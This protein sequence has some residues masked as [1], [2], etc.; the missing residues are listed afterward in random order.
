MASDISV[1]MAVEGEN[2]FKSALKAANAEVK[3]LEAQ[4]QASAD[5][6]D[7]FTSI[8]G[9]AGS[10]AQTLG[11]I[12]EA[13]GQKMSIL[14][15][16]YENAA[17][18]LSSLGDALDQARSEYGEN[19]AEA[20]KAANAYNKQAAEVSKLKTQMAQTSTQMAQTGKAMDSLGKDADEL[21][22][23]LG[24]AGKEA[25]LFGSLLKAN[26][27]SELIT[28]VGHAL[29]DGV[30]AG[31]EA[32]K[33]LTMQAVE[34]YG[35]FEQLEG[36]VKTIFG[37]GAG[38]QVVENARRAF[39]TAQIS[40]NE[41]METVTSF[42]ASL[43]NSL[44]GDTEEAVSLADMAITDMA[45]NANKMGTE[46]SS[47]QTAYAGFARSNYT[48]L[49]N[50]KLGFAGSKEGM[51]DLLDKAE[52][53]SGIH[54]DISSF[55]DIVQAIHIVQENMD[56]A[57]ATAEEA[58][59]T[60]EGSV[61]AMKAAWKNL[62]TGMGD[63]NAD[64][65]QL[66][67][68]FARTAETAIDNILPVAE[69]ALEAVGTLID[70]LAPTV[71][72]KMPG[73]V[74]EV[75]PII[76]EALGMIAANVAL[77]APE[78]A[79]AFMDG[80]LSSLNI[81]P[82]V[83]D[84]LEAVFLPWLT[85][86]KDISAGA[87]ALF[88]DKE[89]YQEYGTAVAEGLGSAAEAS[90]KFAGKQKEVVAAVQE[91]VPALTE[92]EQAFKEATASMAEIGL[93][94]YEAISS[95]GDLGEAYARLS[96]EMAKL[97]GSGDPAI[98][99]IVN[100]RLAMLELAATMQDLSGEYPA[101]ASM[102]E[103]YGFSVQQTSQWLL[104]NGLTA[105]EWANQVSGATD[106]VVNSFETVNT[107]LGM[108]LDEMKNNLASNIE[109]YNNWNSNIQTLMAA[110]VAS[111]SEGAVAFVQYM[112][113]MGIGAADQVAAMMS[114]V[115]GNLA[116]FGSLFEGAGGEAMEAIYNQITGANLGEAAATAGAEIPEGLGTGV[117]GSQDAV[118]G[119]VEEAVNAAV[120]KAAQVDFS[121]AGTTEMESL[122]SGIS[123]AIDTVTSAA[124]DVVNAAKDTADAIEFASVGTARMDDLAS[125]ISS[126]ADGVEN[127]AES[128]VEGAKGR[129]E[130][131]DFT[132]VGLNLARGIASGITAGTGFI[133]SAAISAVNAAK[134]AA[135]AAAGI[136]SPS[137][138][139][140]DEV[141]QMLTKG[142]AAGMVTSEAMS[143]LEDAA[144]EI[145]EAGVNQAQV[146]VKAWEKVYSSFYDTQ[147]HELFM[148]KRH[149]ATNTDIINWYKSMQQAV[150]EQAEHYRA[151]GVEENS[152][153]IM[154]L[155]EKWW[156]YQD[157]IDDIYEEIGD[158]AGK[159]AKKTQ[160]AYEKAMKEIQSAQESMAKKLSSF[161][162]WGE[163]RN[164]NKILSDP[165]EQIRLLKEY[166]QALADMSKYAGEHL[167]EDIL[168]MG[169]A[170]TVDFWHQM[171]QMGGEDLNK[172]LA[173]YET[174]YKMSDQISE[175]Y[176]KAQV[177]ALQ[178]EMGLLSDSVEPVMNEVG[179]LGTDAATAIA[180]NFAAQEGAITA[181]FVTTLQNAMSAAEAMVSSVGGKQSLSTS[182]Y[183]NG[184][185]NVVNGL[186]SSMA[187]QSSG[188]AT[189]VLEVDGAKLASATIQDYRNVSKANP[190]VRSA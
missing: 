96:G 67:D 77:H 166:D 190:E 21:T 66:I 153:Y 183:Y 50:L 35:A 4:L 38:S 121:S 118:S 164:G 39:E 124:E 72:E 184:L 2:T 10:K 187:S 65:D 130:A 144:T 14:H 145:M 8:M 140:R 165:K 161:D 172:Y 155:E 85:A 37:E 162:I 45:D 120:D 131:V 141:G 180:D 123:D 102:A 53:L 98:E 189:V 52:E 129:A 142:M 112:Q 17:A 81:P 136:H 182:D 54:F 175:K 75:T 173:E 48:M 27:G 44:G 143:A 73:F 6:M 80:I 40:A 111:G 109:A 51:Q 126:G 174:V 169:A 159:S 116:D 18:K 49:D 22:E 127:E 82:E 181:A 91:T 113:D 19:S 26:L 62:V 60:V 34:S 107:D 108:S 84:Q 32:L 185:A 15:Q 146:A 167:M 114:D 188:N 58:S 59:T 138:V 137:T 99:A 157:E 135:E 119:A 122:A 186:S 70:K 92:E 101:L 87:Q 7:E 83:V 128:A 33:D 1:K 42:A 86:L 24:K 110:A 30:K 100:Q 158:A 171:L 149:G 63:S 133:Q 170:E 20:Q 3:A 9:T 148:M 139:W 13:Q 106:S 25:G 147:E 179:D 31:A 78:I 74:A 89:G 43:I 5:G 71:A 151:M 152:K 12:L 134:A 69:T 160:E 178:D 61:N 79:D 104:E 29:W 88:G 156:E 11:S 64:M 103:A 47:L 177:E 150:H 168:G 163:D 105:E 23:D 55:S 154:D 76:V 90:E 57:G 41:Y 125:G 28:T 97:A 68:D 95:G 132:S 93:A 117:S 176:Y 115:E 56:I 36:G 46:I 16:Q 94:A